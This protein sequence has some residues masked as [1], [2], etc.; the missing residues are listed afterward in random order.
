MLNR[1][2]TSTGCTKDCEIQLRF[3]YRESIIVL[4]FKSLILNSNCTKRIMSK[5]VWEFNLK[6]MAMT[7]MFRHSY[8]LDVQLLSSNKLRISSPFGL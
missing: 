6:T 4:I 7:V 3:P 2:T 1:Y 8:I 5:D